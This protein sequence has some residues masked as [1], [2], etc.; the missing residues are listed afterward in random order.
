[1]AIETATGAMWV[2]DLGLCVPQLGSTLTW[3]SEG[4]GI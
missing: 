3:Y 4:S 2:R 1:M